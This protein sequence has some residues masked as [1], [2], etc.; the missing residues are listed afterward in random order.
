[1]HKCVLKLENIRI[2]SSR[3]RILSAMLVYAAWVMLKCDNSNKTADPSVSRTLK[4]RLKN[5]LY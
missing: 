4:S 2:R 5:L 1:M 3:K